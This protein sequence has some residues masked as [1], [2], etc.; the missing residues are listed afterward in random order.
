MKVVAPPDVADLVAESGGRL[1][2]WT[3]RPR[4]CGGTTYLETA[5]DRPPRRSFRL[6]QAEPFEV[7]FAAAREPEELH[8]DLHGRRRR[9]EAYWDGCAYVI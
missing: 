2:V 4:C 9:I 5:T 1:F 6:V 7:W 3:R 8:L